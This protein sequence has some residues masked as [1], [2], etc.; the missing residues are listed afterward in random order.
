MNLTGILEHGALAT[1][2]LN[3]C[4]N[5]LVGEE[6]ALMFYLTSFVLLHTHV[7]DCVFVTYASLAVFMESKVYSWK[8]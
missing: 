4:H 7:L 3:L 5:R 6:R 2:K 8:Y 1:V